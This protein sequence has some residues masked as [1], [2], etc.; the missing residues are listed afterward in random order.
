MGGV[1]RFRVRELKQSELKIRM[2]PMSKKSMIALLEAWEDQRDQYDTMKDFVESFY[3]DAKSE[4]KTR[5]K[6]KKKEEEE[7]RVEEGDESE[8]SNEVD[9]KTPRVK[10]NLLVPSSKSK[11]KEKKTETKSRG[12]KKIIT[13]MGEEKKEKKPTVKQPSKYLDF[14]KQ[15]RV[16]NPE[17]KG[18][19]AI[20]QGA[21]AWQEHKKVV[22][23]M[24]A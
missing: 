20:K 8:G 9:S 11:K 22:D 10:V 23:F 18:K 16:D 2:A 19:E 7:S 13:E 12:R 14:L 6:S 21:A 5:A 24:N 1:N 3:Q 17:I 15:W 4:S